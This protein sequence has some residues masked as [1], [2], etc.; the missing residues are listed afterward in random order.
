MRRLKQRE[1]VKFDLEKKFL[2][3]LHSKA[4]DLEYS[5]HFQVMLLQSSIFF[6]CDEDQKC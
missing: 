6:H 1:V 2:R 5:L 3:N 4:V